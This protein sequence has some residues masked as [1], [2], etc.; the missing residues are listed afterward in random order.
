MLTVRLPESVE[1]RLDHLAS[2]TGRTKSFYVRE[3][4]LRHLEEM[5]NIYLSERIDYEIKQRNNDGRLPRRRTSLSATR[6]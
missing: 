5:E 1:K 6:K 3:A 4:I 2:I